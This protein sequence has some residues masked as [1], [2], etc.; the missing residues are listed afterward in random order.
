MDSHDHNAK[1]NTKGSCMVWWYGRWDFLENL[2]SSCRI[3]LA[4]EAGYGL[5]YLCESS[6][7]KP[8]RTQ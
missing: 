8:R 6:R 5:S 1:P 7:I 2:P 3:C 4:L